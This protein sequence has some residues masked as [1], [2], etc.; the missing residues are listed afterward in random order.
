MDMENNETLTEETPKGKS[1]PWGAVLGLVAIVAVGVIGFAVTRN[2]PTPEPEPDLTLRRKPAAAIAAPAPDPNPKTAPV[3]VDIR[4]LAADAKRNEV[5]VPVPP[6]PTPRV[7]A[8]PATPTRVAARPTARPAARPAP[9]E[10]DAE[11][12]TTVAKGTGVIAVK[13]GGKSVVATVAKVADKP[14]DPSSATGTD[15]A[16]QDSTAAA[17]PTTKPVAAPRIY[18]E[19]PPQPVIDPNEIQLP[20]QHKRPAPRKPATGN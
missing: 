20:F 14:V 15:S 9:P 6:L 13:K 3:Y 4:S 2:R 16:P 10:P 1:F 7:P 8:R 19:Q 11:V 18:G 17:A 5:D 12:P